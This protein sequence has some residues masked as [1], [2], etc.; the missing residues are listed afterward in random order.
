MYVC[1]YMLLYIY[2]YL[3]SYID[4]HVF[5]DVCIHVYLCEFVCMC[6]S[7]MYAGRLTYVYMCVDI[8]MY[9]CICVYVYIFVCVMCVCV[10]LYLQ[11]SMHIMNN[12]FIINNLSRQCERNV[13]PGGAQ[14][15]TSCSLGEC[16]NCLDHQLYMLLTALT[17][18]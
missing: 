9:V 2:T 7:S 6:R 4:K 17:L 3:H 16:P 8:Y 10:C 11:I 12:M 5:M 13:A 18:H 1:A 15:L 14:T